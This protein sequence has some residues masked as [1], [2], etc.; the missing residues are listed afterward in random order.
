MNLNKNYQRFLKNLKK[1]STVD[2]RVIKKAYLLAEKS[3]RRQTRDEGPPYII[4]PIRIANIL[5]E[6]LKVKDF[7]I[8][9]AA[10]LHDVVEDAPVTFAEIKKEFDQKTYLL[11]RGMTR[12]RPKNETEQR[13]RKYKWEKLR[14][15]MSSGKDLRLIKSADILD[16]TRSWSLIPKG[17]PNEKKYSRWLAEAK[18]FYLPLA[19]KTDPHLYREIG[20]AVTKMRK[21]YEQF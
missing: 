5:I 15:I 2:Q 4:H 14:K 16:N 21:K 19:E 18:M 3:H 12:I 10:L 1:F 20:K 7:S 8:I 17:H 11:V 9:A 13:K 6:K